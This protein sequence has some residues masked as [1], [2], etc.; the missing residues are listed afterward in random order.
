MAW[1]CDVC[2]KGP[3]AGK[4]ISHSK[5]ATNRRFLPNLRKVRVVLGGRV[6]TM[7]VCTRC[8]RSQRVAKAGPR[9]VAA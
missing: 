1:R 9:L 6:Q 2:S 4:T 3:S 7:L 8:L 5:R